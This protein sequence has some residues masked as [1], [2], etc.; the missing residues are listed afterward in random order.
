MHFLCRSVARVAPSLHVAGDNSL[1][2]V[3]SACLGATIRRPNSILDSGAVPLYAHTPRWAVP[4]WLPS[5]QRLVFV[6]RLEWVSDAHG[7]SQGLSGF[8]HSVPLYVGVGVVL[9]GV[10]GWQGLGVGAVRPVET[11]TGID[12]DKVGIGTTRLCV[13]ILQQRDILG[14]V[15][16]CS[17]V[18]PV[19]VC[20]S[21]VELLTTCRH[22][23]KHWGRVCRASG[24]WPGRQAC[25]LSQQQP[26]AASWHFP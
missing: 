5:T 15:V 8:A 14:I 17:S 9:C 18:W 22:V 23:H 6:R 4:Q 24:W 1:L 16:R 11:G 10:F 19:C 13:Q 2:C 7:Q 20:M 3:F 21:G 25:V 12:A 26:A